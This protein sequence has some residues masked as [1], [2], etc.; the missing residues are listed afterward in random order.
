MSA[1]SPRRHLS[2]FQKPSFLAQRKT[3]HFPLPKIPLK[4]QTVVEGFWHSGDSR[5]S[6]SM[7]H[8][9]DWAHS[10]HFPQ[11]RRRGAGSRPEAAALRRVA[12]GKAILPARARHTDVLRVGGHEVLRLT[13]GIAAWRLGLPPHLRPRSWVSLCP[14]RDSWPKH[15]PRNCASVNPLTNF[16]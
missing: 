15:G 7:Q 9:S 10:R 11:C 13:P 16:A 4:T 2:A 12:P 3:R 5:H 6:S 8:P 1:L 14:I